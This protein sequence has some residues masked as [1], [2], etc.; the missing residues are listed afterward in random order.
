[1]TTMLAAVLHDFDNLVLED[2]PI[3]K[4]ENLG[5]VVVRIASCGIC[6][7]DYKAIKGIRRNVRVPADRRT[8]AERDRGRRGAGRDALQ[9]RRRGDRPTVRLLRVLPA[10]PG[11]Q[12][13]LLRARVHHRRR[14]PGRCLAGRIR[15]VHENQRVVPLP[16][17]EGD[18]LR[19]WPRSPNR[20]PGPGR[21]SSSTARPRWARM[22]S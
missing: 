20:F 13:A 7:T 2:V 5:E 1:M 21:G 4:P 12:H 6:A 22:S 10:L 16:Q 18:Q 11:G 19:R 9:A 3:P 8:R 14:R 15:R 17:A